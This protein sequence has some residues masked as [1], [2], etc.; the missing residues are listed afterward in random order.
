MSSRRCDNTLV[1]FL[2][3]FLYPLYTDVPLNATYGSPFRKV[4]SRI[5]VGWAISLH[6][7][8][9][10]LP[11]RPHPFIP[12]FPTTAVSHSLHL[13]RWTWGKGSWEGG[14]GLSRH[15]KGNG[16]VQ[17]SFRPQDLEANFREHWPDSFPSRPHPR[18]SFLLFLFYR[19]SA[20]F[21]FLL[22]SLSFP[23]L[24]I[25]SYRWKEVQKIQLAV[26]W[27][28]NRFCTRNIKGEKERQRKVVKR[29]CPSISYSRTRLIW[30]YNSPT[31][32][33]YRGTIDGRI[34]FWFMPRYFARNVSN[35]PRYPWFRWIFIRFY[36]R[37][38]RPLVVWHILAVIGETMILMRLQYKVLYL[39]GY[40]INLS[41]K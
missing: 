27:P 2:P 38:M 24:G 39:P 14:G 16:D 20:S 4:A 23:A 15:S 19:V 41:F 12:P 3:P 33:Q 28:P 18:W 26:D 34:V 11:F 8:D 36:G 32:S 7:V 37:K 35:D 21:A 30:K 5:F 17:H 1:L 22:L 10:G 25:G 31:L 29:G 40:F 6:V 13:A 9:N